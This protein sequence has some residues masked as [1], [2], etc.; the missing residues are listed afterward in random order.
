MAWTRVS[1]VE[2]VANALLLYFMIPQCTRY[3]SSAALGVEC[4]KLG[5]LHVNVQSV[6]T[7]RFHG[8]ALSVDDS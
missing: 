3:H 7:A 4:L 6:F 5:L 1:H 8:A 2:K